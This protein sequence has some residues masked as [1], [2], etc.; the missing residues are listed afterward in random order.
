MMLKALRNWYENKKDRTPEPPTNYGWV[1]EWEQD[2][3]YCN[4]GIAE[5]HNHESWGHNNE[6]VCNRCE[7][8]VVFK[9]VSPGYFAVCP[10]HD[11]DLY[12]M[13]T[14]CNNCGNELC[15]C[16]DPDN[17]WQSSEYDDKVSGSQ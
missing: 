3:E 12:Q 15:S 17:R 16:N 14:C 7:T 6:I 1:T 4:A 11:E 10:N 2:C 5:Q 9:D 13:E 8:P